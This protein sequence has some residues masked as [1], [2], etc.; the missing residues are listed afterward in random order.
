M[1][2]ADKTKLDNIA[3]GAQVNQNAFSNVLVGDTT[4]AADTTTD[5]LT[6][7]AG[8]NITLTPDATNDKVTIAATNTT[9]SAGVGLDLSSG[10]FKAK[11]KSETNSTIASATVGTT[12]SRQYA[13]HPDSSGYLS[14]NIP[15]TD[16]HYT[17]HL[18]AGTGTAAN[19]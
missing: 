17:T 3:S 11:L 9:Y 19:A 8:S 15:W 6:L 13:V 5:T 7:T 10:T 14:V 2:S 1:S 18:Y 12:A 4:I 16:T